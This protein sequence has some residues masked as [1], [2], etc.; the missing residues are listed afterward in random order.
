[1]SKEILLD[2]EVVI[3]VDGVTEIPAGTREGLEDEF[4]QFLTAD[5]RADLILIGRGL[6]AMRAMLNSSV[7]TTDLIVCPMSEDE[8]CRIVE[9][10]YR[11]DTDTAKWLVRQ[12]DHAMHEAAQ[13][14]VGH[15]D[16]TTFRSIHCQS[17]SPVKTLDVLDVRRFGEEIEITASARSF[18]HHQVRSMVGCLMM[19][20]RGQW[21]SADLKGALDAKD[22]KALGFN[23]PPD[24]LYFVEARYPA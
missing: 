14:L 13:V 8:Q 19:V 7:T 18:L 22:R 12:V 1:M 2:N 9:S 5:R 17:A 4:K 16:F 15:H 6:T 20:G 21:S 11:L 10:F 23:A 24:G 3:A